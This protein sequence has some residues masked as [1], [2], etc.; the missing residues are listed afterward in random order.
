MTRRIDTQET[1]GC[2]WRRA[3]RTTRRLTQIYDRG[4]EP[5]GITSNQFDLLANLVDVSQKGAP[6][7]AMGVLA[8]QLGMHPTTLNRDLRPLAT[9][10]LIAIAVQAE[11]RRV[12]IV[13][14]TAKGVEALRRA[15]PLWRRAQKRLE[16][17]LGRK[18]TRQLNALLDLTFTKFED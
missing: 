4:L 14:V 18:T 12:R 8:A 3:K 1:S 17:E 13:S 5:S 2:T 15:I 16:F 6:G 9:K 7:I 10:R 11:D